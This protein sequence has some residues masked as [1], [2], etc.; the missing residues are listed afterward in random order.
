MLLCAKLQK[1]IC[2]S[3]RLLHDSDSDSSTM[4]IFATKLS[5]RCWL[6]LKT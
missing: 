6:E 3:L 2:G 4:K 5:M 1:Q